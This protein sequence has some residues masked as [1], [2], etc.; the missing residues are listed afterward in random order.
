M[1]SPQPEARS[2]NGDSAMTPVSMMTA[3]GVCAAR[4]TFSPFFW[5]EARDDTTPSW[6]AAVGT[7]TKGMP[8]LKEAHFATSIDRPPPTPRANSKAPFRIRSSPSRTSSHVASGMTNSETRTLRAVSSFSTVFPA[9]FNVFSSATSKAFFPSFKAWQTSPTWWS[10]SC[11]TTMFRGS[12]IALDLLKASVSRV[13]MG[14]ASGAR[15]RGCPYLTLTTR[16]VKCRPMALIAEPHRGTFMGAPFLMRGSMVFP[17]AVA[18]ATV[19]ATEDLAR[20]EAEF[21]R[22]NVHCDAREFAEAVA[23]YE[24]AAEFGYDDHVMW[25]NRGVALDGLGRHEDAIA[26]YTRAMQR[27]AAYE[28]AAYNL[29]N[30][31]AQLG[32]FDE[33]LVAYDRALAIKPDYPDALFDKAMVLARYEKALAINPTYKQA[34]YNKG[35]TFHG[36]NRLEEAVAAYQ[37]AIELDRGDEVLWNNLGNALY[38]LGRYDESIPYFERGLEVNPEYEIAWNNIGNALN[39]MGRHAESL[40][41]HDKS[42]E[43]KPDFDYALYAKG[44][45]LDNLGRHE[46]GL[47]LIGQSLELNPNY[48][49]AWMAKAEALHRLGRLEEA[50]DALNN[51]L[52]LNGEYE[53][54]WVFRGKILEE[55]GNALE[56][57]RCY[58]EALLCFRAS[59]DLDP[60]NAE[61]HYHRALL[62]EDLER[63]D[64]AVEDYAAAASKSHSA[65][66]LVRLSALLLRLGRPADALVPADEAESRHP[67]DPRGWLA[68][69]RAFA[70]MGRGAEAIESFEKAKASGAGEASL[71]LARWLHST[72]KD[73]E[74]LDALKGEAQLSSEA[75]LLRADIHAGLGHTDES[76]ADHDAA[77]RSPSEGRDLAYRRKGQRLLDLGRPKEAIAAFDAA[78]GLRPTDPE[79]WLD[80]ARG[81]QALGQTARARKMLDEAIRLDPQNVEARRLRSEAAVAD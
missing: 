78:L 17:L 80:A 70:A 9:I 12:S 43:I 24:R 62:L 16:V 65:E 54:A 3:I 32:Q 8:A 64:E 15:P 23:C 56:A 25:N 6:L 77:I 14:V 20:G 1:M 27:N 52:I 22:G 63:V 19:P 31:Y 2:R 81:W 7:L 66:A 38:N 33:A 28:I 36:I 57:E 67:E 74:A 4:L 40:K 50:R 35:Y 79:A 26:A 69:G 49:H 30:A 44:H 71:E 73:V 55:M 34:W 21:L 60:E 42:L 76:L 47:E 53:E 10:A 41:Y 58:D 37:K 61:L 46:E 13:P 48:D 72:G 29:G 45:A 68:A 51:A 18:L 59:L 11:P 39:K 5:I 75:L